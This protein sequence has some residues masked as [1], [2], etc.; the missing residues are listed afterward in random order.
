MLNVSILYS[1]EYKHISICLFLFSSISNSKQRKYQTF[2]NNYF[3]F[4][5][6]SS[7]LNLGSSVRDRFETSFTSQRLAPRN[8]NA[9]EELVV[10]WFTTVD[11]LLKMSEFELIWMMLHRKIDDMSNRNLFGNL[12]FSAELHSK[13]SNSRFSRG[14]FRVVNHCNTC[15]SGSLLLC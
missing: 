14:T 12:K 10:W 4:Y 7:Q 3:F 6:D 2:F 1:Y 15:S 8:K 5:L 11:V 13:S 9:L